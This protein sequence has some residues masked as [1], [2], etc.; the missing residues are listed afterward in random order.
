MKS[1]IPLLIITTTLFASTQR[2]DIIAQMHSYKQSQIDKISSIK[3]QELSTIKQ[4]RFYYTNIAKA[5]SA[6]YKNYLSK[7]WGKDNVKLSNKTRFTQYSKDMDSRESIDF[8]NG[9]LTIEMI[10]DKKPNIDTKKFNQTLLKISKETISDAISKDPVSQL[11]QKYL[12]KKDITKPYVISK[13]SHY[14]NGLFKQKTITK[15]DI[16]QKQVILPNGKKK[17]ITY[18]DVPMVPNYLQKRALKYKGFVLQKSKEYN[19]TPSFVFAIIQ[20]ESYFNPLAKSNIPAYGLMQIVPTTAGVDA[21]YALTKRKRILSPNYLYNEHNNITIGTKYIQ[22]IREQ[23]LKGVKNEKSLAYCTAV[24]YNAGIGSLIYSLTGS[25][26]KRKLAI[27]K[28]NT[29]SPEELYHHLRTSKRLTNEARN[30]VKS[31]SEKSK[32]YIAWDSEV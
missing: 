21:Y 26:K 14:L 10:S 2:D 16:K 13:K 29:M 25:K 20:T 11:E 31:I 6:Y 28:I 5:S 4:N 3:A 15:K 32:K 7:R 30:Y 17:F 22:I 8:K 27:Y 19:L 23:Y 18:V 1:F 24:S 12:V 9:L